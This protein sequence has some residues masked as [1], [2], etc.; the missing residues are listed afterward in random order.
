MGGF[1]LLFE[2]TMDISYGKFISG[3]SGHTHHANLARKKGHI[4][5][6]VSCVTAPY[7]GNPREIDFGSSKREVRVSRGF[8]LSEVDCM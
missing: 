4:T 1:F 8:D 7:E 2:V 3:K 5:V 6:K